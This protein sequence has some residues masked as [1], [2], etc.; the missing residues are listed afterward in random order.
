V[1]IRLPRGSYLTTAEA[2]AVLKVSVATLKRWAQSDLLPSERTEGG[3][4]RFRA[5]DVQAL[6]EPLVRQDDPVVSGANLLLGAPD[7]IAIQAWLQQARRSLGSW[8]AVARPLRS[9]VAELLRRSESGALGAIQLEVALDRLRLALL[10]FCEAYVAPRGDRVALLAAVPGDPLLVAPAVLQLCLPE[11]GW[12]GE[13]TGHPQ[14]AQLAHE[15]RLRP[16]QAIVVSASMG[17][18]PEV[19]DRYARQLG[20]LAA[21]LPVPVAVVG[22]GPWPEAAAAAVTRLGSAASVKDW[23]EQTCRGA[24]A[25]DGPAPGATLPAG[26]RWDPSMALGHATVDAQHETLFLHAARFLEAVERGEVTDG[27]REVLGFIADY[28][29]VHFRFEE[30]LMRDTGFPDA[31]QHVLEHE[32]FVARLGELARDVEAAPGRDGLQRLAQ[33]LAGWLREHVSGSDQRIGQHLRAAA[34]EGGG[35]A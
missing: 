7:P 24:A 18:D 5:E 17:A 33:F 31:E 10:R 2:A 35:A 21:S 30:H 1:S 23:L 3:H 6:A 25:A 29:Q 14:P 8:W 19:V 34:A 20:A 12:C 28:A 13:W 11:S 32:G 27:G 26:L 4:R 9:V 16:V 22:M 15:V